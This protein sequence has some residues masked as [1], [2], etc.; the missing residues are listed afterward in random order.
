MRSATHAK[1]RAMRSH[2]HGGHAAPLSGQLT[3]LAFCATFAA[4]RAV[5]SASGHGLGISTTLGRGNPETIGLAVGSA[6]VFGYASTMVPVFRGGMKCHS[7]PRAEMTAD[8]ASFATRER[9]FDPQTIC[10]PVAP[11][12]DAIAPTNAPNASPAVVPEINPPFGEL[13]HEALAAPSGRNRKC[14]NPAWRTTQAGRAKGMPNPQSRSCRHNSGTPESKKMLDLPS[15][16]NL[17]NA[18]GTTSAQ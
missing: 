13:H 12:S 17:I 3:R 11:E 10:T 2:H 6:F 5:P 18:T 4:S 1:H 8:T 9:A 7:A 14:T 16:A 15:V